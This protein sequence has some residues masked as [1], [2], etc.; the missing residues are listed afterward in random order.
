MR[1]QSEGTKAADGRLNLSR[2]TVETQALQL[3]GSLQLAPDGLPERFDLTGALGI[4]GTPVV[5]P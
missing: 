2:L 1:L 3:N 5:L 4:D